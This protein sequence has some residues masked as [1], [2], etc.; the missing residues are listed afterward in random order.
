LVANQDSDSI[1]VFN[2]NLCNGELKYSGNEY[3]VASPN[4]VCC[5]PTY[6]EDDNEVYRENPVSSISAVK[7]FQGEENGSPCY[8]DSEDSTV[9]V[10]AGRS[11]L[12]NLKDQLDDAREQIEALKK[13]LAEMT[14]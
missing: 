1:A 3:R 11:S 12:F 2:F 6:T 7:S 5:C 13:R 4:F 8:S 14:Q 9:P 10:W